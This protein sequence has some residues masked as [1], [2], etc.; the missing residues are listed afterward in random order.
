MAFK[1][2]NQTVVDIYEDNHDNFTQTGG[3]E[4][5]GQC[6]YKSRTCWCS[7]NPFTNCYDGTLQ[8]NAAGCPTNYIN[9]GDKDNCVTMICDYI[10]VHDLNSVSHSGCWCLNPPSGADPITQSAGGMCLGYMHS[11]CPSHIYALKTCE[12]PYI[13]PTIG[14]DDY[15]TCDCYQLWN[16]NPQ[17]NP[18]LRPAHSGDWRTDTSVS[19][20]ICRDGCF[21]SGG[22][23]FLWFCF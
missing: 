19:I 7:N 13:D 14:S 23:G 16:S 8:C 21:G 12:Y 11:C 17:S 3:P 9:I 18:P 5:V 10:D 4:F 6:N 22:P 1:V 2:N 20:H 15:I